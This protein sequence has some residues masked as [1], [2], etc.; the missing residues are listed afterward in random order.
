MTLADFTFVFGVAGDTDNLHTVEKR[1]RHPQRIGRDEH[2]VGQVITHFRLR[3]WNV[4]FCSGSRTS[5]SAGDD[6]LDNRF[7][8]SISSSRKR[9]L[10]NFAFFILNNLARQRADIGPAMSAHLS[11]SRTPPKDIRTKFRPVDSAMDLPSDVLP[12]PADQRGESAFT[13][14]VR[15]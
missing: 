12:H 15:C 2:D 13:F 3:S 8:L 9:G 11:P 5:S 10:E 4:V 14:P 7:Q 6:R 1:L